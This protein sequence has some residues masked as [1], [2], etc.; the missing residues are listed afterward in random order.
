MTAGA[1]LVA[2]L[3]CSGEGREGVLVRV[4]VGQVVAALW[5]S[6]LRRVEGVS[7]LTERGTAVGVGGL[8]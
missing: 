8:Q 5:F 1:F 3:R 6:W 7:L 2:R 4:F